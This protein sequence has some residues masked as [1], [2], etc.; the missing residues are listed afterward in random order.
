MY[1]KPIPTTAARIH[2]F[3][4]AHIPLVGPGPGAPRPAGSPG[5]LLPTVWLQRRADQG[6]DWV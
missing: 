6:L 3:K 2:G 5:Y 1:F 4:A